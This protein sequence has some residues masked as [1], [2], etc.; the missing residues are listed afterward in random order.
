M[1]HL[2]IVAAVAATLRV[3]GPVSQA[4]SPPAAGF[5]RVSAGGPEDAPLSRCL[6]DPG[7]TVRMEVE[8]QAA[9]DPSDPDHLVAA[10]IV[11]AH[12]SGAIQAAA[13]FDGGL[14]WAP[15]HTLP[16][17]ACAG[18]PFDFLPRTSDPWVAFGP[19]GRVYV[20]AIAFQPTSGADA[21]GAVIVVASANGGHTWEAP[22]VATLTRTPDFVHDNTAIAADPRRPGTAYV[23]TTRYEGPDQTVA[24]AALSRTT[25]GGRTWS[26]I[27]PISP[28]T[29]GSPR[30]D[31][32]QMVID[33]RTGTLFVFYTHGPL[34]SSMSVLRSEDG[35]ESWSPPVPVIRGMPLRVRT[36]T[37]PGT[38]K[39]VRIAPDIGHAAIDPRTGRLWAVLANGQLTGGVALQVGLVTSADG[40]RSW[41]APFRVSDSSVPASWRPAL[42]VD[43]RSRVAVSYLSPAPGEPAHGSALPVSVHLA[44]LRIR[45]EGSLTRERDA[46][47]DS[48]SWTPS[49]R[50]AYFLGDYNPLLAGR[51]GFLP[52][53]GRSTEGGGSR[54]V[55]AR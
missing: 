24:P 6:N 54:I 3:C 14:T 39:E 42:A 47:I 12:S 41:S 16:F 21:A 7:G 48:F 9:V 30:A 32:P 52:I 25:D 33:P 19:D 2:V 1:R 34:G 4:P 17:N 43:A 50:G 55:L 11:N 5:I 27:R 46:V 29:P 22:G 13:S 38:D 26:P 23:L 28:R 51:H 10:W 18:G 35:G 40:G 8:P 15:P 44:T 53:Y 36:T 20:S 45:R 31:A 49:P 37:F